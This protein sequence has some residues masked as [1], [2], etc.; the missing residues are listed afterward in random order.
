MCEMVTKEKNCRPNDN[1]D[2]CTI[3]ILKIFK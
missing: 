1:Q 3:L 2:M